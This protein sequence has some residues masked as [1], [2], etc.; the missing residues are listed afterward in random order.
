[1]GFNNLIGKAMDL[2]AVKFNG[3]TDKGGHSY[4]D[5][6]ISVEQSVELE[7]NQKVHD[8]NSSLSLF[9]DKACVV[10]LLHDIFEDTDTTEDEL[11]QIGCDDEIIN[12]IKSVTRQND[13]KYYFDFILR[14]SKN[15]IGRI[16]KIYDIENNMD[17]KRLNTFNEAD[18]NRLNKYWYSW[19]FL[20]GDI[21]EVTANN[22]IHPDR[23]FR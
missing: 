16:V 8:K 21:D 18:K 14:A 5:H 4:I 17:I 13:E 3:K 2:A 15:D 9:Y 6:L 22:N 7:R 10:A 19:K 1:M 20:K 23:L 12:A 11:R